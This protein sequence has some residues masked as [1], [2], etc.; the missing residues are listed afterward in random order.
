MDCKYCGK[1]VGFLRKLGKHSF[2]SD[3]H[4]QK[5]VQEHEALALSR[6]QESWAAAKAGPAPSLAPAAAAVPEPPAVAGK[7]PA[8]SAREPEPVEVLGFLL[9]S[10]VSGRA[11]GAAS[12]LEPGGPARD[13]TGQEP[14][15]PVLRAG[16]VWDPEGEQAAGD[17][18]VASVVELAVGE[19]STGAVAPPA[20][21]MQPV[22]AR[23]AS[24]ALP[25]MKL[26]V[27]AIPEAEGDRVDAV[28]PEIAAYAASQ[29]Q[30]EPVAFAPESHVPE[31]R[32]EPAL[33]R[34]PMGSALAY[35]PEFAG[36]PCEVASFAASV[37]F[38]ASGP[39]PRRE[40]T[41]GARPQAGGD[42][43]TVA[44]WLPD[45]RT[46]WAGWEQPSGPETL[47]APEPDAAPEPAEA[48][49]A[50]MRFAVEYFEG[51]LRVTGG[52]PPQDFQPRAQFGF[53]P[54]P[55]PG[56]ELS[57]RAR[58]APVPLQFRLP[59]ATAGA[60][61]LKPRRSRPGNG[62]N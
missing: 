7:A 49:P 31:A 17:P 44:F 34:L 24:A 48:G 33:Q 8:A 37:E 5:W 38:A 28:P 40:I 46:A 51:G 54:R 52:E 29:T 26:A 35:T 4:Q 3:A 56:A 58:V 16:T 41:A 1:P 59:A 39:I 13:E 61:D 42:P 9:E 10:E 62:E 25:A 12:R 23:D 27:T 55:R 57:F 22:E 2:C 53:R 21:A 20:A 36:S 30:P 15:R 50:K 11:P 47:P 43:R 45:H 19:G 14:V 6:L 60:P 18:P 32:S